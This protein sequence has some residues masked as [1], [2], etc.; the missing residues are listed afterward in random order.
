MEAA[1]KVNSGRA[2]FLGVE[3]SLMGKRW[4]RRELDERIALALAQQLGLEEPVARVLAA[5]RIDPDAAPGFLDPSL[6]RD[7]PDPSQ[8]VDMNRAASLIIVLGLTKAHGPSLRAHDDGMGRS[9]AGPAPNA[10]QHG[11][12]RH[13]RCREHDVA[14]GELMQFVFAAVV[15]DAAT[16]G[17][18]LLVVVAK[19]QPTLELATDAPK[20]C[21]SEDAF[22]RTALTDID[23]NAAIRTRRGND[24]RHVA[25]SDQHD[26]CTGLTRLRDQLGVPR[27]V[28]NAND[29][30]LDFHLLRFGQCSKVLADRLVKIDKIVRQPTADCDLVHVCVRR[31]QKAA[32]LGH[33][34]DGERILPALS[35]NRGAFDDREDA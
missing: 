27:P 33:S 31:V 10:A 1:R 34:D 21:R 35:G 5:R 22:W 32:G 6:R 17:T 25:I 8:L 4:E 11:A 30:I 18:C 26:A 29:Q 15:V 14:A 13:A 19:D 7:L 16:S 2:S 28:K 9:T 23:V 24:P 12:V 20:R 3:R